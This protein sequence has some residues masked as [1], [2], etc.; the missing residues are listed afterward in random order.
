LNT[1][2]SET[3]KNIS[4]GGVHLLN[5]NDNL[6]NKLQTIAN[7]F[8]NYFPTIA[9]K[10]IDNNGNDKI[11]QSNNNNNSLNYM[12]QIFKHPFPNITFN[13]M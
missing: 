13:Y 8:Y 11:G 9:D 7:S 5:I 6:A 4:K 1:N 12:L 10:I 3:R 2:K